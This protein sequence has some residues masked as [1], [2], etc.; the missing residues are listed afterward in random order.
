VA[1]DEETMPEPNSDRPRPF[2]GQ[3]PDG[4]DRAV[5]LARQV[6]KE[7]GLSDDEIDRELGRLPEPRP[8]K[9]P[10]S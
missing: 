7:Q 2:H 9:P 1:D 10:P 3:L 8:K 4:L 6:L 5:K